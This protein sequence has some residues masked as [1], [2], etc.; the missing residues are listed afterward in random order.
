MLC[1][2]TNSKGLDVCVLTCANALSKSEL[3][4]SIIGVRYGGYKKKTL[5]ELLALLKVTPRAMER[6]VLGVSVCDILQNNYLFC[7]KKV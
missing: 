5:L 4:S 6:V 3:M 1:H 7:F 2:T